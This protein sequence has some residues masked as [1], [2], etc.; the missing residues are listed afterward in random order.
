MDYVANKDRYDK[1][2]YKRCGNSG[3]KLP[4]ISLGLWHNFG[5]VDDFNNSK[6][7]IITA[8]NSDQD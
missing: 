3:L 6:S 7:I 5:D 8:L 2:Q 1:I 4:E